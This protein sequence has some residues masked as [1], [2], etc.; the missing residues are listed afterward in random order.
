TVIYADDSNAFTTAAGDI[1]RSM[2]MDQD[3]TILFSKSTAV[4][5]IGTNTLQI[6]KGGTSWIKAPVAPCATSTTFFTSVALMPPF[7]GTS[8]GKLIYAHQGATS[9][10]NRLGIISTSGADA[11][12]GCLDGQT[13]ASAVHTHDSNEQGKFPSVIAFNAA[14]G[15]SPTALAYVPTPSGA[16]TGELLVAYSGA[17]N[18]EL[19]NTTN[20]NYAIVMYD[21]DETSA[22][23]ATISNTAT[24]LYSDF[25]NIFGISA[26]TY[27]A[28]TGSLY[29][30]TASQPGI[31]NQTTQAYGYKI[32]KFKLDLSA[33]TTPILSL[34]RDSNN[35]PFIDR[36]SLT[37]CITS[38]TI[39][40]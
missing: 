20:L 23:A 1:T 32:E 10:L 13:V 17:V 33:T 24:V 21:V 14:A 18:T 25:S 40:N 19:D 29:V 30:A 22:V 34:I 39:G 38:M 31:A 6:P 15:S 3:S 11:A 26:M 35:K 16:H 5:K 4:E 7:T 2:V 27:D 37:K 8:E 28:S 36:S 9:A 12:T